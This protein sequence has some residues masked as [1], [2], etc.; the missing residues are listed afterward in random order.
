MESHTRIYTVLRVIGKLDAINKFIE[1]EITDIWF[2]F[3]PVDLQT[4]LAGKPAQLRFLGVQQ[5]VYNNT[6]VF[7]LVDSMGAKAEHCHLSDESE[8]QLKP[9][10]VLNDVWTVIAKH[11]SSTINRAE[12]MRASEPRGKDLGSRKMTM[13]R[14]ATEIYILEV[15]TSAHRHFVDFLGSKRTLERS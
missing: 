11:R 7:D 9:V 1:E 6:P 4:V 5:L 14:F 10:R 8:T 2:P 3:A 13:K 12:Y 15:V